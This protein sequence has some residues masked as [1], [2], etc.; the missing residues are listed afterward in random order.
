VARHV[1][2]LEIDVHASVGICRPGDKLVV[3]L[4]R[5]LTEKEAHD[6]AERIQGYLPGV[7]VVIVE[8]EAL[9]VYRH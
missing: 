1:S 3:A 7:T 2:D 4:G 5:R 6:E 9:V 8:A